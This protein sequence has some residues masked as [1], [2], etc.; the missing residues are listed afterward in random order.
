V[1]EKPAFPDPKKIRRLT[2]WAPDPAAENERATFEWSVRGSNFEATVWPRGPAE[3]GKPPIRASL[4]T[5]NLSA[6][7]DN[8]RHVAN[9]PGKEVADLQTRNMRRVGDTEKKEI[10]DQAIVRVCKS[11]EGIIFIGIFDADESRSRIL[12]PFTLDRWTGFIKRGGE[13]MSEADVSKMVALCTADILES[14]VR[15]NI[16]VTSDEKN[17]ELYPR[18]DGKNFGKGGGRQGARTDTNSNMMDDYI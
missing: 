16:E 4:N 5:I 17:R 14:V 3:K 12:F 18:P 1:A 7:I 6:L 11:A 13:T 2:M 8:I 10:F 15:A 9:A